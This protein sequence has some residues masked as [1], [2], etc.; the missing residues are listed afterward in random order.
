MSDSTGQDLGVEAPSKIVINGEE[1]DPTEAQELIGKGKLTR[2]METKWNTSVD[3]VWPE[4]GR[5]STES[6]QWQSEKQ[7]LQSQL[8]QYQDKKDAGTETTVDTAKA[9]DAA[10]KLGFVF[11][12]DLEKTGYVKKD[13]LDKYYDER[14]QQ[15]KAVEGI[16]K[17]A[18][19]LEKEINGEDGRPKFQKKSVLAYAQAYGFDDLKKAY[20]DMHAETLES[21][22][23][24]Q[25]EQGKQPGLKTIKTSGGI[26]EPK[27][28]KITDDNVNDA[29]K[30]RLWGTNN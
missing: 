26:K 20:E 28:V 23:Q 10:R 2:E 21:W 11:N 1:Y 7:A 9:R 4:F 15:K 25:I 19:S 22:K 18:D 16:L 13:D 27:P 12:E 30:E 8:Q 29:L 24:S 3:K 14:E 6:K 5:L 17:S